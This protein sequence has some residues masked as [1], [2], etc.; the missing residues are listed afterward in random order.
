MIHAV[1]FLLTFNSQ[2][3]EITHAQ[4]IGGYPTLEDCRGKL[5][6][7]MAMIAP[8]LTAGELPQLECSTVQ[9]RTED[10][11]EPETSKV[12]L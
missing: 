12:T 4:V 7:A 2:T 8:E 9:T 10:P 11:D 5:S 3:L 1:L 6:A